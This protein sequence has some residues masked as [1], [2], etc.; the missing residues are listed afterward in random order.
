[1]SQFLQLLPLQAGDEKEYFLF[2]YLVQRNRRAALPRN[3]FLSS[4]PRNISS[5]LVEL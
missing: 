1:M 3:T 5:C 4:L 2:D